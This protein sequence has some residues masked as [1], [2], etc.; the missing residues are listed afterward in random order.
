MKRDFY[1]ILGVPKSATQEEIKR[2]YRKLAHQYH[3]DKESGKEHRFKEINEAYQV[4]G[5]EERRS[6]YDQF[7]HAFDGAGAGARGS[8]WSDIFGAGGAGPFRFDFGG[9]EFDMGDI[10][11]NV[12]GGGERRAS[13][14]KR[15]RDIILEL[16][17]PFETSILGGTEKISYRRRVHCEI[18]KGTGGAVG[19]KPEKCSDCDGKGR[20]K[21]I[22]KTFLGSFAQVEICKTCRGR[23]ERY[24]E[25]CRQCGGIGSQ[26]IIESLEIK[27]PKGIRNDEALRIAG[28]GEIA[29]DPT[30][31]SGN[32]IV[33]VRV[34][35]HKIFERKGNDLHM[36]LSIPISQA[37]LGG[38]STIKT[39][40]GNLDLKI[41]EGSQSGD[42]L[43]LR[44]RGVAEDSSFRTGDL[45]VELKVQIPKKVPKH[46]RSIIE[47]LQEEGL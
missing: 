2:A 18:C 41:P 3:P 12:F 9:G 11:E 31:Q 25:K 47:K 7:G 27:I 36:V 45:L 17:I 14:Q 29:E 33:Q 21:K 37:V 10:F 4:L 28:K 23:G 24:A 40:L 30:G 42:V 16:T 5:N 1:E 35:Q 8:Q 22:Q 15:G 13:P 43:K 6:K 44:G 46:L 39:L 19:S 20:I 34:L 26:T 38:I 32:L